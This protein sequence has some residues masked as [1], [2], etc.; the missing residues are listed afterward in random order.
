VRYL[1][2]SKCGKEFLLKAIIDGEIV[3]LERKDCLEC[4]PYK[5][6]PRRPMGEKRLGKRGVIKDDTKIG[7]V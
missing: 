2:C 3:K 4:R 1:N 5:R 6:R 7:Q